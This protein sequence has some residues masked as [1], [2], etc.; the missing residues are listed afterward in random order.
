MAGFD[1][2]PRHGFESLFMAVTYGCGAETSALSEGPSILRTM[3]EKV[4]I[5]PGDASTPATVRAGFVDFLRTELVGPAGGERERVL[6]PPNRRYLMGTLF[7]PELRPGSDAQETVVDEVEDVVSE[8]HTARNPTADDAADDEDVATTWTG[9]FLPV[10]MG[11]S[12]FTDAPRLTVHA[13]AARYLVESVASTD[14]NGKTTRSR[15][16]VREPL[17]D[18]NL[19]IEAA[20]KNPVFSGMASLDVLRRPLGRGHLFTITLRNAASSGNENP[21][22]RWEEQ[23]FQCGFSVD[24]VDGRILEYPSPA[25]AVPDDEADELRL[26]YLQARAF[27]VGHGCA[28]MWDT[29]APGQDVVGSVRTEVMP[30][31]EVAPVTPDIPVPAD[32]LDQRYCTEAPTDDVI[33]GMRG[34]VDAYE[35]WS[36]RLDVDRFDTVREREAAVRIRGRISEVI[37]RMR[38]GID[39]LAGDDP[40]PMQAFRLANRAMSLQAFH[41]EE[42]LAGRLRTLGEPADLAASDGKLRRWYPFQLGFFLTVV[43]D[44]VDPR[45]DDRATVDLLWFPTGGGKTEAY[46]LLAAF[47]IFHRRLKYKRRGGGT[48]VLSRY[49]LSLLTTQQFQRAAGLVVACEYLRRNDEDERLGRSPVSIGIWAGEA[50]T[51]NRSNEAVVH[52]AVMKED[53]K[54]DSVF[55]LERCPWCG[56]EMVPTG[57]VNADDDAWGLVDDGGT[58]RFR[59]PRTDCEFHD[60]LPVHVVDDDVYDAKPTFMLGTVDK[61][62]D[63]AWN[64]RGGALFGDNGTYLPPTLIIQ[65]EMHLLTGPLGTVVALYEHAIQRLC[66]YDGAPAK[67]VAS[68]ATVRR[69]AEQLVGLYGRKSGIFPPPGLDADNSFFAQRDDTRPG[70][71]YVGIMAQGHTSDTATVHTASAMLQAPRALGLTGDDLDLYWTLVVYHSSL[72]ELGRTVTMAGDDIPKRLESRFQGGKRSAGEVVELTS[73]VERHRQPDL[74]RQL[75]QRAGQADAVDVLASTNMLSVGVDVP[76]LGLMLVNGQP[77]STSEYI[78]ATSRVGRRLPGLVVGLFRSTRPRDRSH[79]ESFQAYHSALYRYVEPTSVTPYSPQART[80]ALHA[81][82]VILMRHLAGLAADN[83]AGAI[84]DR[85]AEADGFVAEL[86]AV[87]AAVDR[88][89]QNG[90]RRDLESFLDSWRRSA[91]D[92]DQCGETLRFSSTSKGSPRLLKDFNNPGEGTPTMRSMRNVDRESVVRVLGSENNSKKAKK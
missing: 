87:A 78:Q 89:E 21:A 8:D 92:A 36:S 3:D 41:A 74:L 45:S 6:E 39:R 50:T 91:A 13:R 34:F 55:L 5:G 11:L 65:D 1:P 46:L 54:P 51:P 40:Q 43:D 7:P 22:R 66:Q 73:N 80:R 35:R 24:A 59:C 30:W 44:L 63:L 48:T 67:V 9:G 29:P 75:A 2:G 83:S 60:E 85:A 31:Y 79:Y 62:A 90:V 68:T 76:R 10:S 23:L 49:T 19:P 25:A 71:L 72:R 38:R 17:P 53:P 58:V 20:G 32:V 57:G 26:R 12:F 42:S 18:E 37:G 82:F 56:T 88:S 14:E 15:E 47:E 16:W 77:K 28:A 69:S 84:D 81:S 4:G 64:T 52:L 61:F 33:D 70:R 86:V 27:A